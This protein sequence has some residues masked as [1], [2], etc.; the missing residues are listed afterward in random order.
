MIS[1]PILQPEDTIPKTLTFSDPDPNSIIHKFHPNLS[2]RQIFI[3]GSFGGTYWRPIKCSI[4]GKTHKNHHL[5]FSK[6]PI[7]EKEKNKK[8]EKKFEKLQHSENPKTAKNKKTEKLL[9][10][11]KPDKNKKTVPKPSKANKNKKTVQK[12]SKKRIQKNPS[13]FKNLFSRIPPTYLTTPFEN[14]NKNINKYKVKC[15]STLSQWQEKNWIRA[16]DPYGWVEWYCNFY[17]GRR[18][19]DD[20]RQIKRWLAFCGPKGRFRRQLINRIYRKK[21]E[22]DDF[23]VSPVVR[24]SLQH[25]GFVL[26]K[27]D[28]ESYEFKG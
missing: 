2:P 21:R 18:S 23:G 12:P 16:Q 26:T 11:E 28:F 9:K 22:F 27:E 24:Q 8:N 20:E 15:G 7:T 17:V 1:S 13:S 5:K 14:Y 3:L 6:I 19:D 4:T 10:T 25:W